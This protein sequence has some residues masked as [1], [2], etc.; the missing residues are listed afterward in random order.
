M[1]IKPCLA[2]QYPTLIVVSGPPFLKGIITLLTGFHA[3]DT[4]LLFSERPCDYFNQ[5]E[6]LL[7]TPKVSPAVVLSARTSSN[8]NDW[9]CQNEPKGLLKPH[10][11]LCVE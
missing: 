9:G 5:S 10:E 2:F 11:S 8:R 4:V 6:S 7:T 3:A 1:V